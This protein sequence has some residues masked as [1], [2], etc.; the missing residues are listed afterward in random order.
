MKNKWII[1]LLFIFSFAVFLFFKISEIKVPEQK[2]VLDEDTSIDFSL[3]SKS[4]IYKN[5]KI[6][7]KRLPQH[8]FLKGNPENL[9]YQPEKDFFGQDNILYYATNG[10]KISNIG[11]VAIQVNPINDRPLVKNQKYHL[12][13]DHS[14]KMVLVATDIDKDDLHFSLLKIPAKGKLLGI[15]PHL[16]YVPDQNFYGKDEFVYIADDG[17]L[18]SLSATV[19]IDVQSVND[20]P[21]SKN[22]QRNTYTN[23]PVRIEIQSNDVEN[24]PLEYKIVHQPTHGK[25]IKDRG[26]YKYFP[27]KNFIG[28]DQFKYTAFDGKDHSSVAWFKIQVKNF[29]KYNL[30]SKKLR[31][32]VKYGGIAIGSYKNPD[33]VFHSEEYVPASILKIATAAAALEILGENYKFKTNIYIDEKR[34]LY[35]KG[36]GD[37]SLTTESWYEIARIL[38]AKEIFKQSLNQLVLDDTVFSGDIEFDGREKNIHYFNAPLG[39]LATN[40]NTVSIRIGRQHGL[41]ALIKDTPITNM[42]VKK[43]RR[44]PKGVQHFSIAKDSRE[45][46]LYTG[47]LARAIFTKFGAVF[48][49]QNRVGKVVKKNTLIVSHHSDKTLKEIIKKLLRYSNNFVANQLLLVMALEKYGQGVEFKQGVKILDLYI[50]KNIGVEKQDYFIVEGSGLSRNNRINL[51]AMLKVVNSFKK[52]IDLLPHLKKSKFRDLVKIGKEWNIYAK[53]G[54][55]GSVSTLAGFFEDHR[56]HWQPFV[57]MLGKNQ[58]GRSQVLQLIKQYYLGQ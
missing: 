47:E 43:A 4:W 29:E 6:Q 38:Q 21:V 30:L 50:N 19:H 55:L 44:L 11:K 27:N 23:S 52:H 36:F 18:K 40:T 53:S 54:T 57:V 8:G 14:I 3:T 26:G 22:I 33:Y 56:Q 12:L 9:T 16:V 1:F 5:N 24:E 49:L 41:K 35:I 31:R 32:K 42:I 48:T 25:L 34:N 45:S 46:T 13:E 28:M 2:H 37:P 17:R 20:A 51:L 15:P 10:E 39:A 7:I 58:N